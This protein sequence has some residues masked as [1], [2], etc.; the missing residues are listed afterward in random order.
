MKFIHCG[1]AFYQTSVGSA[2]ASTQHADAVPTGLSE[3]KNKVQH[4]NVETQ[5]VVV[6]EEQEDEESESSGDDYFSIAD[7]DDSEQE[8]DMEEE[9]DADWDAREKERQLVLEAAGLIVNQDVKPPP[10]LARARSARQRRPP[11]V[12]P[13]RSSIISNSS[14]KDLP[15]VPDS[16][17]DSSPRLDDAFDRY[18]SFK[19]T[20]GSSNRL[21]VAS[22]FETAPSSPGGSPAIS[23]ST[24]I[25]KDGES[26]PKSHLLNFLGRRT[27]AS[28]GAEKRT[29]IIS[30]P[31]LNQSDSPSREN[32]PAFGSV[33]SLHFHILT[34]D[35]RHLL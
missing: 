23:F 31:I 4:G 14:V 19:H 11:P 16:P 33:R 20:Q 17:A 1:L 12:A 25:S 6:V 5:K 18:E 28:D 34:N 9:T 7:A 10:R 24:S 26:R 27:P 35:R 22:S 13:H 3:I 15:P 32:S 8:D 30:G 21:S 2:H 29:L